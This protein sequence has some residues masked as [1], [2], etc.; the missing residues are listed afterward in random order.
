MRQQGCIGS[1]VE[2]VG[3]LVAFVLAVLFCGALA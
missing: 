1:C 2:I 3:I